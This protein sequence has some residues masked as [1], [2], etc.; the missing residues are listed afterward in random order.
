MPFTLI[1]LALE[2]FAVG[3]D[4]YLIAGLLPRRATDMGVLVGIAGQLVT[5]FGITYAVSSPLLVLAT[6]HPTSIK[7]VFS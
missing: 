4:E 3:T 7:N 1:I 5:L 6:A 2:T